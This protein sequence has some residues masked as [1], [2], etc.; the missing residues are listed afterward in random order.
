MKIKGRNLITILAV[1][2]LAEFSAY[3]EVFRGDIYPANNKRYFEVMLPKIREAKKSVHVIMYLASYYP[4]YPDS[5]S[6][7]IL[8]ELIAAK[9]RGLEVEIILNRSE[10]EYLEHATKENLAAGAYL[11]EN[12]ISPYLDSK[13]KTTHCKLMVVDNR[14]V[15]IGSANWT[16][17]AITKNNEASV[18]IESEELAVYYIKYFEGIKKECT[19]SIKP[20]R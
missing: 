4:K 5:P 9:K 10:S 16:Y 18:L 6:N 20:A 11:A 8:K 12:G 7:V 2:F 3:A 14:F 17:S 15:L 1:L 13:D 19:F